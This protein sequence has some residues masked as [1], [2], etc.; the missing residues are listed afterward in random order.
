MSTLRLQLASRW[1]SAALMTAVALC[2]CGDGADRN[3]DGL[4]VGTVTYRERVALPLNAMVEIRLERP[5]A[6]GAAPR[7]LATQSIAT[8]GRQ[9]PISF[10]LRYRADRLDRQEHYGL[11][12]EIRAANGRLLFESPA[13]EPVFEHGPAAELVRLVLVRA[14]SGG[15]TNVVPPPAG[16]W[17]LV[18]MRREQEVAEA[19]RAE[20][21]F[22]IEFATDGNVS[23]WAHCNRYTARYK[24]GEAGQLSLSAVT[25]RRPEVCR[26][27]SRSDEILRALDRTTRFELRGEELLLAYGVGGELTFS[28]P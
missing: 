21:P 7:V 20:P 26:P 25:V 3:S 18:A 13:P 27:P 1:P 9:V 22:S 5:V 23:G 12:A 10:E 6:A 2:G 28:R 11:R 24:Q 15:A 19:M 8:Q 14:L 17:Q 4:I 16:V